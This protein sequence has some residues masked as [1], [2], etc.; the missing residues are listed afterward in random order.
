MLGEERLAVQKA[1]AHT[2]SKTLRQTPKTYTL[3]ITWFITPNPIVLSQ[4]IRNVHMN[5]E[6]ASVYSPF[7]SNCPKL[8][9]TLM[10][11]N[12]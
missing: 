2:I 1:E 5:T 11:L 9:T 6:H 3:S 8:E 4:K 7:V 10:S 12:Q